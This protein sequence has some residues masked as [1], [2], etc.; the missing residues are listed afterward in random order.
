VTKQPR[1]ERLQAERTRQLWLF[2]LISVVMLVV[3]ANAW[4]DIQAGE[5]GFLD[6]MRLGLPIFY[7]WLVVAVVMGWDFISLRERKY[8]DDELSRAFRA[9]SL[10]LAFVVLMAAGTI[11]LAIS[12]W[13]PDWTVPSIVLAVTLGG[14][15]AGARFAWLDR[16]AGRSDG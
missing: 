5:T 9:Q 6:Y 13:R 2:P 14:S 4:R 12:L 7:A 1:R 10:G 3:A 15:V 8:L 11:V 16:Q